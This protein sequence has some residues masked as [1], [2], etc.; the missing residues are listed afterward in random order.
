MAANQV[1]TFGKQLLEE[2]PDYIYKYKGF[3][4]IRVLGMINDLAG[5]SESGQKAVQLNAFINVKTAEKK[6]QFGPEKCHTLTIAHKSVKSV[7]TNLYIDH[8]SETH[9]DKNHLVEHFQGKIQMKNFSEQKHLG[10]I[11]G[12]DGT[13]MKNIKVK[14]NRAIGIKKQIEYMIKGL[15]KYTL[16]GGMVFLNSLLRSSILFASETMYNIKEDEFRS[17]ERIEEDLLRIFFK[18]TRGCPIFQLYFESGHIPARFVI[19]RMKILFFRYIITQKETSLMYRFIMAQ[20][21]NYVKGDWYSDVKNVLKEFEIELSEESIQNIPE[22]VF[23]KLVRD[24]TYSAAFKYLKVKQT[25]GSK[26]ADIKY[27]LIELQDYL[28]PF[29]NLT[30]ED[31]RYIFSLRSKMNEIK[32]NFPKDRNMKIVYCVKQC[33]T[34]LDNEHITWCKFMNKEND[35]KYAHILNGDISEKKEAL[36]KLN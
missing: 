3:I 19:K 21:K 8:W 13:N 6:L 35:Y 14:Q 9:D 15:G 25:R 17:I 34:E 28:N 24:K 18:T 33:N 4:P 2:E 1:D 22:G 26:G 31:Q 32:N 11:L 30:L 23:K 12:E 29:A 27:T 7:A 16:E 36:K 5:V 20:K 10:F